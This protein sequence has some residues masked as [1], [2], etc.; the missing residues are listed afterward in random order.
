MESIKL[1]DTEYFLTVEEKIRECI[2]SIISFSTEDDGSK[3]AGINMKREIKKKQLFESANS[4]ATWEATKDGILIDKIFLTLIFKDDKNVDID[5]MCFCFDMKDSLFR[6]NMV[7]W[8]TMI[9]EKDG[10]LGLCDG[11]IPSVNI[12]NIPLDIPKLMVETKGIILKQKTYGEI[13]EI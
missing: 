10:L 7:D 3:T 6:D 12:N 5:M 2:P 13:M 9:I 8:F 4:K 1:G 11:I